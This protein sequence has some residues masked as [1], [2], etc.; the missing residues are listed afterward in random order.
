[1]TSRNA[2][3]LA[4][5]SKRTLSEPKQAMAALAKACRRVQGGF[6]SGLCSLPQALCLG[7]L[8]TNWIT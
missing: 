4:L 8:I 2:Q 3:D 5:A 7:T 1:M 6:T